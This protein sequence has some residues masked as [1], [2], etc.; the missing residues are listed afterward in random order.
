MTEELVEAA[1]RALHGEFTRE[2]DPRRKEQRFDRLPPATLE[3]LQREV[4]AVL[5]VAEI[6]W[7][8]AA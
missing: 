8:Q 5:K 7:R 6:Y 1:M 2:P 3:Q 4:V